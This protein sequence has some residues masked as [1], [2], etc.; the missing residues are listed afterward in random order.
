MTKFMILYKSDLSGQELMSRASAE[1]MQSSM[2]EW[3]TW[4]DSLPESIDFE[5]GLPLQAKSE[6][7]PT[8]VKHSQNTASGYAI[9]EGD[10]GEIEENLKSHPHLK[11]GGSS[12]DVL[13]ML[14]MPGM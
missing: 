3:M 11:R 1:E 12:I 10:K 8:S 7:T 4:K 6:V 9:M 2:Q 14:H 5:W 13:E